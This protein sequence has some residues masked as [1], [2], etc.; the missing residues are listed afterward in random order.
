MQKDGE[1]LSEFYLIP[2]KFNFTDAT[3]FE[4]ALK[5]CQI[6]FLL[7]PPQ[8]SDIEK[9]FIS[10]IE[11]AE[12]YKVDHIIFLSVQ[13]VEKSLIIPPYKIE[14]L[15]VESGIPYTFLRSAYF[16]QNFTT[17]LHE[18]LVNKKQIHFS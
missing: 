17:T 12:K 4:P 9:Y 18:D 15:I 11:I 6:L 10:L 13:G 3:T 14:K 16:M 7:R 8:I 2:E 1:K 5:N